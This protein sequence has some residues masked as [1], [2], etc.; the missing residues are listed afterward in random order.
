MALLDRAG[1]L[2]GEELPLG[3]ITVPVTLDFSGQQSVTTVSDNL[4]DSLRQLLTAGLKGQAGF[5]AGQVYCFLCDAPDC[6]HS[7]PKTGVETFA[8]YTASG[9]PTWITFL[10]LCLARK[11][12][13]V[14]RLYKPRAYAFAFMQ[15]GEELTGDVLP[16]FGGKTRSLK[17]LGQSVI[18]LIPDTVEDSPDAERIA[19]T[20][21]L[22]ETRSGNAQKRLRLNILG[23]EQDRLIELADTGPKRGRADK[24]WYSLRKAREAVDKLQRRLATREKGKQTPIAK[25]DI[26]R[27]LQR[28]TK[29]LEQVFRTGSHRT[30]HAAKRHSDGERPTM[31][32]LGDAKDAPDERLFYDVRRE[33]VVVVG[34]KG[35]AHI[36]TDDGRHVTSMRLSTGEP[37]RKNNNKR[38]VPLDKARR[39]NFKAE[40]A[41]LNSPQDT[42]SQT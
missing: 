39:Q 21:Q 2:D 27:L 29:D 15:S 19:L 17:L 33:T 31:N 22:I 34:P 42:R 25:E 40:L 12:K 10:N 38:W 35:R 41:K 16:E 5:R 3:T 32:A 36:F 23:I 37:A 11:D 20:V 14:D 6:E 8:G 30:Q 28:I 1:H 7:K 24:L 18:G 9:K 4:V 13:R 26:T